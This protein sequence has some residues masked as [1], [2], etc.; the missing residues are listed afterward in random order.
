MPPEPENGLMPS[1][2]TGGAVKNEGDGVQQN[3]GVIDR[4][5]AYDGI[6]KK[7][8]PDVPKGGEAG[9]TYCREEIR[10][11]RCIDRP[12]PF[13]GISLPPPPLGL[14]GGS[15]ESPEQSGDGGGC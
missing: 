7:E 8:S 3:I 2:R 11:G 14:E 10:G 5:G 4:I 1:W 12:V 13:S 15:R 9:K 6:R